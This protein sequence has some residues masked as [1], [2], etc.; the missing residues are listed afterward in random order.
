MR[1]RTCKNFWNFADFKSSLNPK[2][3]YKYKSHTANTS[4]AIRCTNRSESNAQLCCHC[5][6]CRRQGEAIQKNNG[7][8]RKFATLIFS[9]WRRRDS[10]Y[11]ARKREV[12]IKWIATKILRIFSQWRG[13]AWIRPRKQMRW[14]A[15]SMIKQIDSPRKWRK[16][17]Y[18]SFFTSQKL[19]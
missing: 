9:Q 5:E 6:T 11:W 19:S 7:L 1:F 15:H 4:I 14:F 3:S 16:I 12:S 13:G 2:N 18:L 10:S 8:P 17:L